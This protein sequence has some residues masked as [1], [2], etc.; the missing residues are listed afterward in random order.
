M[1]QEPYVCFSVSKVLF[2]EVWSKPCL[3]KNDLEY[4]LKMETRRPISD[5]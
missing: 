4:L 3:Q 2:L 1:C 5:A